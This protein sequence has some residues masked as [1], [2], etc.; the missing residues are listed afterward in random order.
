MKT[1]IRPWWRKRRILLPLLTVLSLVIAFILAA[2]RSD[3]SQVVI[4]NESGAPLGPLT[5]TACGQQKLFPRVA[6]DTSVRMRLEAIGSASSVELSLP[7]YPPWRWDGGYLEPRG[8]YLVFIHIRPNLEVE[9]HTQIS[10]WQRVLFNRSSPS[11]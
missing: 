8:G 1:A 11:D 10:L 4:Y 9:L 5:V 6:D 2:S 3:Q 7:A